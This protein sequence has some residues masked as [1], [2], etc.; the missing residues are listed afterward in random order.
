MPDPVYAIR[1]G[2]LMASKN[3]YYD[4][5]IYMQSQNLILRVA[6]EYYYQNLQGQEIAEIEKISVSTVS[7]LLKKAKDQNIVRIHI[8]DSYI[9]CLQLEETLRNQFDLKDVIV[10]PMPN[11]SI[12]L[13]E[14]KKIV[15]LEGARYLQR[16]ITPNDTLG[17]A[18][19]E[20]VWYLY[21][22]LNPSQRKD[23]RFVT[24]HGTLEHEDNKLDGTYL[25]PR[26]SK[27]FSNRYDSINCKGIQPNS[28]VVEQIL[29][30]KSISRV[31][32][33][34][35]DVTISVSGVGMFHPEPTSVLVTGGY[36]KESEIE[37][38]RQCGAYGDL[39]LRFF[40]KNGAE[41]DTD[42]RYRTISMPW[43]IY[44]RIQNKIIV[45]SDER[46]SLA[47]LTLLRNKLVD[48]LIV[49]QL[50]AH[51]ICESLTISAE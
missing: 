42:L 38:L 23:L 22:Y 6:Y 28:R 8:D 50:L 27:A 15:A 17:I 26:I 18:Y 9:E 19:G 2:V 24:L 45:A 10:A 3:Q 33:Q 39:L 51:R 1:K 31:F 30:Q 35:A 48:T 14:R 12:S 21:N 40:D 13:E 7:R 34:F 5:N 20:T 29:S 43:S 46:K 25:L 49:D 36:L 41:C 11:D 44:K 37:K 47:I 16:T 32:D 4:S